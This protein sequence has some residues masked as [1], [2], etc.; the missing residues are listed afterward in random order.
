MTIFYYNFFSNLSPFLFYPPFGTLSARRHVDE[1][2][3]V[4]TPTPFWLKVVAMLSLWTHLEQIKIQ[5]SLDDMV[6]LKNWFT[7]SEV[8]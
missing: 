6:N 2:P 8:H 3:R 5:W 7:I 4:P 1:A